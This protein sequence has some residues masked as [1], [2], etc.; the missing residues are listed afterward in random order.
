MK[1][2]LK[3]LNIINLLMFISLISINIMQYNLKIFDISIYN[4]IILSVSFSIGL[5]LLFKGLLFKSEHSIWFGLIVV[6]FGIMLM[7]DNMGYTIETWL[8]FIAIVPISL[9]VGLWKNEPMQYKIAVI[10]FFIA[11]GTYFYNKLDTWC[12]ILVFLLS[13]TLGILVQKFIPSKRER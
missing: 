10:S 3:S 5:S 6:S 13:G 7:L 9:V 2:K 4:F 11:F 1:L 12:F 8:Y